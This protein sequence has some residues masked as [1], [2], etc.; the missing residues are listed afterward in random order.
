MRKNVNSFKISFVADNPHTAQEVTSR[1]TSL[2]IQENTDMREHQATVTTEFLQEQ[3][4]TVKKRLVDQEEVV[5]SFK[6]KHL[7][8]LPEQEQGNSQILASL[9]TQLQNTVAAL[10]RAEEQKAYLESLL[11]GYE[12][13]EARDASVAGVSSGGGLRNDVPVSPTAALESEL[14]RLQS[15]KATLLSKYT[16]D[17]PDVEKKSAEIARVEAS[18]AHLKLSLP[19]APQPKKGEKPVAVTSRRQDAPIAQVNSQLEANRVEMEHLTNDENQLK[20]KIA[21]YQER[22]NATPMRE[23]QLAGMLRDYELLRQNYGDL[24]KKQEESGLAMSLEKHQEGQQFRVV[25][26]ASLPV[27]PSFPNRPLFRLGG[28]VGGMAVGLALAF[29][30]EMT[31]PRFY[32]EKQLRDRIQVPL[33]IAVP[34]LLTRSEERRRTSRKVFEWV[35]GSALVLMVLAAEFY[36]YRRG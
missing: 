31:Q 36:V 22:L 13:L 35:A 8:E 7:G 19:R 34:V 2:F 9:S 25:D 18:L 11:R 21:Q 23:Q 15:E 16:P 28:A 29:L 1:V 24:L 10:G 20:E 5:R 4:E 6:M 14:S 33:V 27:L 30:L 32:S 3:L 17:H 26:P 12:D